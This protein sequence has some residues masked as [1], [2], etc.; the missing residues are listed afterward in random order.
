MCNVHDDRVPEGGGNTGKGSVTHYPSPSRYVKVG[1]IML[2]L[3]L[4]CQKC[5]C[6]SLHA[7]YA[8]HVNG[9]VR[10]MMVASLC[11]WCTKVKCSL[12][13]PSQDETETVEGVGTI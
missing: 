4:L 8:Q 12:I 9:H 6:H 10:G 2:H 5:C 7:G 13:G 11:E 1:D 3:L